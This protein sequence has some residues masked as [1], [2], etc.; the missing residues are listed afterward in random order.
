VLTTLNEETLPRFAGNASSAANQ[1]D[2]PDLRQG[3]IMLSFDVNDSGRV[4][5]LKVVEASPIEFESMR[6]NVQHEVRSRIYRIRFEDAE[7]VH[8]PNQALSHTFF[9]RQEELEKLR[10][11]DG[12]TSK[13]VHELAQQSDSG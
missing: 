7:P 1:A 8:T 2:D 6:R 4:T 5:G 11:E 10:E 13:P 12:A 3:R 9:Y